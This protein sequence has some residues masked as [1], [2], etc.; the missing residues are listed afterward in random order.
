MTTP[1][2][3]APLGNVNVAWDR[4]QSVR[5]VFGPRHMDLYEIPL[6]LMA[7]KALDD[8]GREWLYAYRGRRELAGRDAFTGRDD[9]RYV[10]ELD[11]DD[12][13]AWHRTPTGALDALTRWPFREA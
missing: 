3:L 8:H 2:G 9:W 4:P 11:D 7:W 5:F 6:G 1:S 13:S 10:F 12:I